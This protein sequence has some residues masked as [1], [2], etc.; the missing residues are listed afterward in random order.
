MEPFWH[1]ARFKIDTDKATERY[2]SS[3]VEVQVVSDVLDGQTN[4]PFNRREWRWFIKKL[5]KQH[6]D[7]RPSRA[8]LNEQ[9]NKIQDIVQQVPAGVLQQAQRAPPYNPSKDDAVALVNTRTGELRYGVYD[10]IEER[11]RAP[12]CTRQTV[13]E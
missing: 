4:R 5:H 6:I 2:F 3:T 12:N 11:R 10:P 7:E 9:T 13:L 8:F 1:N